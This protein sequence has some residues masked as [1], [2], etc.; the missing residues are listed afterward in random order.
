MPESTGATAVVAQ[1]RTVVIERRWAI[2]GG[3]VIATVIIGLGVALA[4]VAGDDGPDGPPGFQL[5]AHE[6]FAPGF[7]PGE[8][9]QMPP[10]GPAI[11]RAPEGG[12]TYPYPPQAGPEG[13][14]SG[15][16]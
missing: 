11:P 15:G 14:G 10:G 16:N 13:G 8:G 4:I 5:S 6:G 2:V 3:A 12:G 1:P 7:A 9:G